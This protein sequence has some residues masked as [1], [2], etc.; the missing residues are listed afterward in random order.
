[1][2]ALTGNQI[3]DTYQGLLKLA[4]SSTGITQNFQAVQDGLGNNTGVRFA[5]DQFEAPN[6]V[7]F[8]NLK[9]QYYGSGFQAAAGNQ[10]AAG[11]QN[12]IMAYPFYDKGLY[13]YSALT[14]NLITAS[15]TSDTCEAAIYTTQMINPYG[16]F[17]NEPIIS[18]ITIPTTG[19]LG[20]RTVAFPSN[21]S[22][23]GYGSGVYW[24]VFKISNAGVQPSVRFG[25]GAAVASLNMYGQI[26]SVAAN[27]YTQAF[28]LNGNFMAFSGK[29]TFDNPFGTNLPSLQSTSQNIVGSNLGMILH[30]VDA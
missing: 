14:F 26:A 23:S 6:L 4:D 15:T 17:P 21:I 3:K 10:L 8:V 11:T 27:T 24:V 13:E 9:A 2:S 20:Q 29:T 19:S 22:M 18:G 7:G 16:I 1:M 30:T 25:S 12:I 5:I 28:R